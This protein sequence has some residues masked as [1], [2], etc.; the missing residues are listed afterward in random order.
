MVETR[1]QAMAN[2]RI[3][4]LESQLKDVKLQLKNLNETFSKVKVEECTEA[5]IGNEN[6]KGESSQSLHLFGTHQQS[7]PR[8]PKLDMYKF[9]GSHS[10]AWIAQMD[11]YFTLNYLLDD[12]TQ[13]SVGIMYLDNERWQWWQWHQH[14]YGRPL[15]WET[16]KKAF[17]DR[18]DH[19]SDFLGHITKLR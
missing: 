3:D 16:F 15:T 6:I 12:A 4:N 14:C 7:H 2:E 8:P 13:L 9:D 5:Y 17:M 11:Q 10:V 19:E 18:F 1:A